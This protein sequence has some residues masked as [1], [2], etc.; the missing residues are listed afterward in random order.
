MS[1]TPSDP[2]MDIREE[3]LSGFDYATVQEWALDDLDEIL[4]SHVESPEGYGSVELSAVV[5]LK[6]GRWGTACGWADTTGWGCQCDFEAKAFATEDEAVR[7]GLDNAR[8]DLL[9]YPQPEMP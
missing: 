4:R 7:F 8:R 3:I 1:T 2:D 6:D 9:G 5:R